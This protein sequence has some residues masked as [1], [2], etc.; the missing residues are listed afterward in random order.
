MQRLEDGDEVV[1][2]RQLGVGGVE[3]VEL[4]AVLDPAP[5]E[6]L[7]GTF[8]RCVV[9]IDPVDPHLRIRASQLDARAALPAR[10]IRYSCGRIGQE[11]LVDLRTAGSHSFPSKFS[12]NGRVNAAWPSCKS[13]P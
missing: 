2:S 3:L 7:A 1:L 10:E 6:V 13:S 5:V 12:N 9:G 11:P 8:G 4:H